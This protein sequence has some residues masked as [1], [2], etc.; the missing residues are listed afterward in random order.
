MRALPGRHP[1]CDG[2]SGLGGA[3]VTIEDNTNTQDVGAMTGNRGKIRVFLSSTYAHA[4]VSIRNNTVNFSGTFAGGAGATAAYAIQ[5]M[6]S[7]N[8]VSVTGNQFDGANVADGG[9]SPPF[10]GIFIDTDNFFV[11]QA[12]A[13][14]QL[15]VNACNTVKDFINGVSVYDSTAA[16]F[17]GL[18][19]GVL[20]DINNNNINGNSGFGANNSGAAAV[21]NAVGNWWGAADGPGAQGQ[22]AATRSPPMSISDRSAW[23]HAPPKT[24]I[25]FTALQNPQGS[26]RSRR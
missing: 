5:L 25:C 2:T 13:G 14:D 22:A 26:R 15:V 19:A 17:G 7:L 6:G 1:P 23:R 12:L 18:P 24:I 11:G 3:G 16:T 8:G 9:G 21:I 4:P 10:S 20:V